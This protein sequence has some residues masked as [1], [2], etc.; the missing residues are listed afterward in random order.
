MTFKAGT[1]ET[2]IK[3]MGGARP[4]AGRTQTTYK[5]SVEAARRLQDIAKHHNSDPT[6]TI[7]GLIHNY[8]IET[9]IPLLE[10]KGF[11]DEARQLLN[12][13]TPEPQTVETISKRLRMPKAKLQELITQHQEELVNQGLQLHV[14]THSEVGRAITLP[15]K[16]NSKEHTYYNKIS[17]NLF[18]LSNLEGK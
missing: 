9:L 15:S 10:N 1:T 3:R 4:G 18:S 6:Q 13:L 8:Y 2:P 7:E 16:L 17:R 11:S 14:A 12:I 5:I